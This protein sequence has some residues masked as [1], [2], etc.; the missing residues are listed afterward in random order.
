VSGVVTLRVTGF[1]FD[2]V[3]GLVDTSVVAALDAATGS[4]PR[5]RGVGRRVLADLLEAYR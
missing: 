5:L 1:D 2:R 3:R 4:D